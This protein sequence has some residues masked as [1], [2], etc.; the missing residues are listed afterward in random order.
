MTD[1]RTQ[2]EADKP[3]Y[4]LA[5]GRKKKNSRHQYV[6]LIELLRGPRSNL[7]VL[8][9][10][11]L[12]HHPAGF[13]IDRMSDVPVCSVLGLFARHGNKVSVRTVNNL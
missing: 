13:N 4:A 8:R 9:H 10:D 5:S 1:K 11:F 6:N 3:T 2:Q 12:L 7:F